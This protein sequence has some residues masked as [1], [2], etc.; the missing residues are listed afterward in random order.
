MAYNTDITEHRLQLT[1]TSILNPKVVNETRLQFLRSMSSQNGD[2]TIPS[3]NVN[4]AFNGGG[5]QVGHNSDVDTRWEIQNYTTTTKK[6]HTLR[7]GV[8]V[9]AEN[10]RN[11]SP[12]NF[13]GSFTFAGGIGPISECEQ[14][15]GGRSV[16]LRQCPGH[17]A[18]RRLPADRLRSSATG[19][20]CSST[21]WA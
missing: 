19:A 21:A 5:A 17:D 1:E 16:G 13:G 8:R 2:N 6:T 12:M 10:E 3:I 9:R 7:F 4:E 14:S 20:P 11:L 15:A 18:S